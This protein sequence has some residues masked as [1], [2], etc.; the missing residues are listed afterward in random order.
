MKSGQGVAVE[1]NTGFETLILGVRGPGTPALENF[2][3]GSERTV[4][5]FQR[6]YGR[7]MAIKIEL[8]L[9]A[10]EENGTSKVLAPLDGSLC[11]A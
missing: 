10:T 9:S 1:L 8:A 5:W 11:T 2:V 4:D 7:G 3:G 6:A